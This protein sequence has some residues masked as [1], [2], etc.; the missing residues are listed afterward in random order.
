MRRTTTLLLSVALVVAAVAMV[1]M[2]GLAAAGDGVAAQQTTADETPTNE[3]ADAVNESVVAPGER[4]SG[5]VA[6]GQSELENDVDSRAFGLQVAATAT[7]QSA[8][9]DVVQTQLGDVEQRI[10]RLA[11]RKQALDRARDNGSMSEGAYRA[12]MANVAAQLEGA[13]RLA[14]QTENASDGLPADL[15]AEKGINVTA[16]QTLQDRANELGGQEVAEI[17][18][19]IAGPMAG[20]APTDAGP[21]ERGPPERNATATATADRAGDGRIAD[22]Q[23][24][25]SPDGG[26]DVNA[27]ATSTP[28]RDG[29]PSDGGAGS[30]ATAGDAGQ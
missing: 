22:G 30:G 8:R 5:V 19:S 29:A 3:T 18:R 15:L 13:E 10:D 21:G 6:V 24:T 16:I 11:E 1:P 7:N 9:A 14:N 26:D 27:T 23:P 12:R 17:A 28:E 25:A 4:L 2:G 20:R